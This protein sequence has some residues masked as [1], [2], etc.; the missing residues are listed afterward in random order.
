M[1]GEVAEDFG[2]QSV[3]RQDGPEV[4]DDHGDRRG[5]QRL[6]RRGEPG[7]QDTALTAPGRRRLPGE[8]VQ[9]LPLLD[10]Q[11]QAARDGGEHR[12]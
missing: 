7:I 10:A 11:P 3:L 12:R 6:H 8:Q 2:A 4:I 5:G 1:I 9:I